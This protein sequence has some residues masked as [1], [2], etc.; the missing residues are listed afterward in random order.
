[1]DLLRSMDAFRHVA[2]TGG[3]SAAAEAMRVS[4]ATVTTL[5]QQLE[6]HLGVTL[7]HRTTRKVSLT[8]DGAAALDRVERLLQDVDELQDG[9][10]GATRAAKGRLRVDVPAAFG[11]H[12]LAPALPRFFQRHPHIALEVGSSD[13]P[14]D[15]IREGVDCVVRGG[16][17]FDESL[18][19]RRLKALPVITAAAPGYLRRHGTPQTPD[20]CR[21]HRAVNFFSPRSG[22]VFAFDFAQGAR[23]FEV[24]VPHAVACNDSD[25]LLACAVAGLGLVQTP[26]SAYVESLLRARKLVR[27]LPG[28][29]CGTLPVFVLYPPTRHLSARVRA[30]VEWL[31]DEAL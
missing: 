2:R 7:F 13:R 21:R 4:N 15:L 19:A 6:A 30:F 16:P 22:E 31:V 12:L 29:D 20:E 10:R 11:R 23:T 25:T 28:W 18:I 26:R 27:V 1:M 14:V 8:T 17:V 9:V 3:F 5:V 24:P